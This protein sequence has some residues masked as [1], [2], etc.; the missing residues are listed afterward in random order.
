[1]RRRFYLLLAT[2]AVG[3]L[4]QF[5]SVPAAAA[6]VPSISWDNSK[7][8]A[9]LG[10]FV[11]GKPVKPSAAQTYTVFIPVACGSSLRGSPPPNPSDPLVNH[12]DDFFHAGLTHNVDPR[13]EAT[14]AGPES[15]FGTRDTTQ[16][17]NCNPFGLQVKEADGH[18]NIFHIF[19]HLAGGGPNNAIDQ[20]AVQIER[21]IRTGFCNQIDD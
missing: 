15:T 3:V 18:V 11:T 16:V 12:V 19:D 4:L 1:M 6:E 7:M 20:E 5:G 10:R 13:F 2:S 8:N 21:W 17:R 9:V 14:I